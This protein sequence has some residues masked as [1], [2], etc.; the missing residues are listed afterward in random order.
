MGSFKKDDIKNGKS[1]SSK[2]WRE[3]PFAAILI[4]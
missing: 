1:K 3:L 2:Y 4:S